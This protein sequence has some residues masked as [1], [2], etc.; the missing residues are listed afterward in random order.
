MK[1]NKTEVVMT[2]DQVAEKL[3]WSLWR[4]VEDSYKERYKREIWDHFENAIRS[5]AYTAKLTTFLT[6]FKARIPVTFE[7]QFMKNIQLVVESGFDSDILN[8]LRDET[9]YLV[10]I[11]RLMNQDRKDAYTEKQAAWTD[12]RIGDEELPVNGESNNE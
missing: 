10:M 6:N 4:C 5:A 3:L 9:T 8:W 11:T 12:E 7:A 1:E 2:H